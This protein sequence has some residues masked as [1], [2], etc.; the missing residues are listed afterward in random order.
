[1]I[2]NQKNG[3]IEIICGPMFSGKTEE[4]I[5]RLKRSIIAKKKIL[6]FKPKIDNRYSD[7]CVVTHNKNSIESISVEDSAT[8]KILKLSENINTIGI[9]EIQFFSKNIVS[10]CIELAKNGKRVIVSGLDK[11]YEGKPFGII[12]NLLCEA[13]YVTKLNAICNNCG[14]YAYFTKRISSNKK[15]ILLG[16]TDIYEANCRNCFYN[17]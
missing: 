4:L 10:I 14:D 5:R 12:P 17:K 15:Q 1:M 13:E 16:E 2:R 6:V 11:D 3:S 7:D 9:D 8:N